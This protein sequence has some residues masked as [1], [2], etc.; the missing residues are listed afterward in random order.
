M[1]ECDS[2][3]TQQASTFF[4]LFVAGS[5]SAHV[6]ISFLDA[7]KPRQTRFQFHFIFRVTIKNSQFA[8]AVA[9]AAVGMS[10]AHYVAIKF[11]FVP[12]RLL[13]NTCTTFQ[14]FQNEWNSQKH[15]LTA[16][17]LADSNNTVGVSTKVTVEYWLERT[18]GSYT[19]NLNKLKVIF[20]WNISWTIWWDK[21]DYVYTD[22][23]PTNGSL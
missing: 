12:M 21:M 5:E 6:L 22:S 19:R 2:L 3:Y 11:V 18:I 7:R 8:I 15:L 23:T 16:S 17:S 4:F 9:A 14:T 13:S 10:F 20:Y 1:S